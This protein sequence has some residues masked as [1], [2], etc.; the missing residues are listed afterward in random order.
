MNI[1]EQSKLLFTN[2]ARHAG[3]WSGTPMFEGDKTDRGN[4]TQLKKAG[5]IESFVEDGCVFVVF[6][7]N[8]KDYAKTLGIDLS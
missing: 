4:L 6:T 8:G 3:D 1:T 7:P 5:L 2:L